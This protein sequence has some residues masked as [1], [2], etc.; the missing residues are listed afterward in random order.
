MKQLNNQNL[1]EIIG[2]NKNKCIKGVMTSVGIGLAKHGYVGAAFGL[3]GGIGKHC[4]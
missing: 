1:S 3:F 4:L 2:G